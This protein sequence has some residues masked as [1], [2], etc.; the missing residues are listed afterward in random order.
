MRSEGEYDGGAAQRRRTTMP[1][2][3][4]VERFEICTAVSEQKVREKG[5]VWKNPG[6]EAQTCSNH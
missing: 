2:P 1:A 3:N 5:W 6:A 4:F